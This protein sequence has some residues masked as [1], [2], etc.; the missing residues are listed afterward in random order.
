MRSKS[1][2]SSLSRDSATSKELALLKAARR[3]RILSSVPRLQVIRVIA[4]HTDGVSVLGL[5]KHLRS[6]HLAV[7]L[8]NLCKEQLIK[9]V[10][11]EDGPGY[12]VNND[13]LLDLFAIIGVRAQETAPDPAF[14]YPFPNC[15]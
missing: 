8:M 3:L 7:H 9:S 2:N 11:C 10:V 6:Q 12:Q 13:V 14:L 15:C 4:M 1:E 5:R